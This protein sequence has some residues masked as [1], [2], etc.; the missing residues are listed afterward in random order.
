MPVTTTKTVSYVLANVTCDMDAMTVVANLRWLVDGVDC[1]LIRVEAQGEDFGAILT[2][3]PSSG[4]SRGDD[5][6]LL[7]YDFAVSRGIISG[8]IS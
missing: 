7:V 2:A 6:A 4:L 5:I 3:V 1:G 8:D